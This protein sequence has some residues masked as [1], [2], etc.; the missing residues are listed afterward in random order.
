MVERTSVVRIERREG[1]GELVL[2]RPARRNALTV[3]LVV[4]LR[5][6]LAQLSADDATGAILVR[7]EGSC[8]CSGLDLRELVGEANA[9]KRAAFGTEWSELHRELAACARPTIAVLEG[10]AVAAGAAL[11]LACDFLL[12][13]ERASLH[14]SEVTRA[15]TAPMNIAWLVT[16]YGS[17]RAL[18]LCVSAEPHDGVDLFRLGMAVAVVDD[19]NVL[20]AAREMAARLSGYDRGAMAASKD[21]IRAAGGF[22]FETVLTQMRNRPVGRTPS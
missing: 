13:G 18:D 6:G 12:A 21:M 8:L 20:S 1:W 22:D 9:S 2:D 7:G 3:E 15:M 10:A 4:Q 16:K 5:A 11:A 14:V 19:A 17:A